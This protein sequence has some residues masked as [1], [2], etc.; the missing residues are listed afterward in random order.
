MHGRW[1]PHKLPAAG[2]SV[3][4]GLSYAY[5]ADALADGDVDQLAA[6]PKAD[7]RHR[8]LRVDDGRATK[9]FRH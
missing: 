1:S 3:P 5:L 2:R 4:A 9:A 8:R 6:L 7:G